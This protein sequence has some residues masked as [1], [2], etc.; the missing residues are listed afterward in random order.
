MVEEGMDAS[1][2]GFADQAERV[3]YDRMVEEGK[4]AA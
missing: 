2:K 1:T 3:H 4:E